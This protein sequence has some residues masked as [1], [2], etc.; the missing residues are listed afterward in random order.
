[1]R[2]I[3]A[4]SIFTGINFLS[5][6]MALVIDDFGVLKDIVK[7]TEIQGSEI[8]H[9]EGIISPGFV[10]AHCHLELSHL[11][12]QIDPKTGLIEFLKQVITKRNN[13]NKKE[14]EDAAI[15][16]DFKMWESGIVAVGDISNINTTFNT[17]A[18]SKI[19]Y[20]TFIEL[21]GLNP[22]HSETIFEKGLSLLNELENYNLIGSL[23]AHAPFSSSKLLINKIANYNSLNNLAFSIHN[24]ESEEET[25]FF[26]GRPSDINDLFD[27]LNID[28]NWFNPPKTSSLLSYLDLIPNKKSLLVHNTFC[29]EEDIIASKYK[30]INWCFCPGA[31][32][33]IE[34]TLPNYDLFL[35]HNQ[36]WCIGTDSLAS[37]QKLDM[38]FEASILLDKSPSISIE[39]ILKAL[40]YNGAKALGIEDKFGKLIIGKNTGLNLIQ[41]SDKQLN[42][43][44][45]I[46]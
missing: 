2:I 35:N 11:F 25:K 43:I 12:S 6:E 4:N 39:S 20:H 13:F 24:Q 45:K 19:Y 22:L 7:K 33:F 40:T 36:N 29:K 28:I 21:I 5:Q 14:Q 31:N 44:K 42:F 1:M 46:A 26:A 16:A 18:S 3:S 38:C 41:H 10:N 9:Y 37:N 34:N 17:K 8:E 15:E 32:L 27:Y 30:F 23:A